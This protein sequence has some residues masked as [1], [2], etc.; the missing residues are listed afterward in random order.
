MQFNPKGLTRLTFRGD[1][2][3]QRVMTGIAHAPCNDAHALIRSMQVQVKFLSCDIYQGLKNY[4]LW[5]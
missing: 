5:E 3:P 4:Y 2:F 1:L